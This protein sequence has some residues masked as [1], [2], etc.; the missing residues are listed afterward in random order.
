MLLAPADTLPFYPP[1]HL[2]RFSL[3]LSPSSIHATAALPRCKRGRTKTLWRG[4]EAHLQPGHG[5]GHREKPFASCCWAGLAPHRHPILCP[6][7]QGQPHPSP[8]AGFGA[9]ST[10]RQTPAG[11][12]PHLRS[13]IPVPPDP[14]GREQSLP[15]PC[16]FESPALF[17]FWLSYLTKTPE[18]QQEPISSRNLALGSLRRITP[19]CRN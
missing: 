2:P 1:V 8:P 5:P 10:P 19:G 11:P 4:G 14:G 16:P 6:M 18:L 9:F 13:P 15:S 7:P 12:R 17:S 3:Y